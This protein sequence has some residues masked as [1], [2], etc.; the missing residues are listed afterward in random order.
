MLLRTRISLIA[1]VALPVVVAAIA[2]PAV[3]LLQERGERIAELQ[4]SEQRAEVMRVLEVAARP[5]SA[6]LLSASSDDTLRASLAQRDADALQRRLALQLPSDAG[7]QDLRLQVIGRGDQLLAAAPGGRSGEPMISTDALFRDLTQGQEVIGI[8]VSSPDGALRLVSALRL[9]AALLAAAV[10]LEP[11]LRRIAEALRAEVLLADLD[12]RPLSAQEA[13]AWQLLSAAGAHRTATPFVID[14]D[15]GEVVVVPTELRS[16]SGLPLARLIVVRDATAE[17]RRRQVVTLLA[18]TVLVGVILLTGFVMYRTMRAALDPLTGLSGA[19]RAVAAGDTFASISMPD[20]R[21]EV[22]EI[23]RAFEA[24]RSSGIA[25]DRHE[26]RER[27]SR[28]RDIAVMSATIA[29]LAK[30]LE[31]SEREEAAG[32]LRRVESGTTAG[33]AVLA[34]ALERMADGV[35]L[36]QNRLSALLEERTRDLAAVR[37]ALE[38]RVLFDRMVEELEVARRLQLSSLPTEFP[39]RPA[40]RL[41]AAMR[42]AKEVGGDFY[43]FMMLDEH[44]LVLMVGDA[45]GK[46]VAGAIFVAM[47]RSLLHAAVARGASPGE[48]LAQANDTL[49]VDNPSMMFATAFVGILDCRSGVLRYANAGHNPPRVLRQDGAEAPIHGHGAQG[50][51]LGIVEDFVFDEHEAA[52]APGDTLLLFSDGVT[53]AQ[54]P[55]GE[56]F[57]DERLSATLAAAANAA[58]ADPTIIVEHIAQAVDAFAAEEPQADDITLLCLSYRLRDTSG[59]AAAA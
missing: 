32:L 13:P 9:E 54:R 24:L 5:L 26:T 33:G 10:P 35:L 28:Q 6:L 56:L 17:A 23:A 42:P 51:A 21:D 12:G 2:V 8:A 38:Q 3:L 46:G 16:P 27:L 49:A 40:F 19:L 25:L 31:D 4:L 15:R 55:G 48:A 22:G 20:R 58:A 37:E 45:S 11:A 1:A 18:L 44:R 43:D 53:E 47:T 39:S 14:R 41:H 29:R 34:T 36:R 50:I 52:I 30:V 57:G 7:A 59:Q